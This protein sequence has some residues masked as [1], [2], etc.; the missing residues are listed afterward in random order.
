MAL[1]FMGLAGA[2]S[3]QTAFLKGEV[4]IANTHIRAMNGSKASAQRM[5]D[6]M[7]EKK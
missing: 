7:R 3:V 2:V 6:R 1:L 4:M 5:L